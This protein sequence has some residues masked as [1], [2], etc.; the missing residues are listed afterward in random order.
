MYGSGSGWTSKIGAYNLQ[1]VNGLGF[2]ERIVLDNAGLVEVRCRRTNEQGENN[3]RDNMYWQ[4]LRGRL[5]ARPS[6]YAGV[7]TMG[8]TV[9]TGGK[10]AAQSDKRVNVVAT[11]IYGTGAPRSISGALYHVGNSLGLDMDTD[12]IDA[13]ESAYWTPDNEFFDF[14]TTDSTSALE[15]LQKIANAGKSYFLLA[16]G[17]ASVAREGVKPWSGL[18]VH[19]R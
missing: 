19:M 2:T 11:K 13:L 9:E 16:D 10:L 7:T 1:N 4:A 14:E 12:A 17:L 3:A 5:L 18:S 6:S 8:A 15:V